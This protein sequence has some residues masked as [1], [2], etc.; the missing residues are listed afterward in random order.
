MYGTNRDEIMSDECLELSISGYSDTRTSTRKAVVCQFVF[1]GPS[2]EGARGGPIE[3]GRGTDRVTMQ[4]GARGSRCSYR[5]V[6]VPGR[7][8]TFLLH[9]VIRK[10]TKKQ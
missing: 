4:F 3:L 5:T 6:L 1:V 8:N 9:W 2:S 7:V 10:R